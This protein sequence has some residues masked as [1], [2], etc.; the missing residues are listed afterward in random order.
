MPTCGFRAP[1]GSSAGG[2]SRRPGRRRASRAPRWR[3]ESWLASRDRDR[4]SKRAC[5]VSAG[6]RDNCSCRGNRN[7]SIFHKVKR[8]FM[9]RWRCSKDSCRSHVRFET[10]PVKSIMSFRER[11]FLSRPFPAASI[12][13]RATRS[14]GGARR[15]TDVRREHVR[16][17]GAPRGWHERRVVGGRRSGRRRRSAK[18]IRCARRRR[19]CL[20]GSADRPWRAW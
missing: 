5:V 1:C 20:L 6:A 12:A 10:E 16:S 9:G 7:A 17:R 11:E 3:G 2:K 14:A 8:R 4:R 19:G 15:R 18:R 13:G